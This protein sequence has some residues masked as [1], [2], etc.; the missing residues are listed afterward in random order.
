RKLRE[1]LYAVEAEQTLGKARILQ[2]YL[3][4]A[5]W[6][7]TADGQL[8]CGAEAA[9]RH[10]FGVPARRLTA[11]QAVTLAALLRNPGHEASPDRLLWVAE[12]VRGV[13][14]PQRR[15]LV[16]ALRAD[17]GAL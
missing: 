16:A 13:P 6:G 17:P 12:Q 11:R 1:L 5:P 7:R 3:A 14:P 2:L 8:V 10:H 15:A 4:L 9:A